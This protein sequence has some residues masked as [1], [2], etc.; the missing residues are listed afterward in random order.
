MSTQYEVR[1]HGSK[2]IRTRGVRRTVVLRT[3]CSRTSHAE[4]EVATMRAARHFT[5]LKIWQRARQGSKEVFFLAREAPFKS[6]RRPVKQINDSSESVMSN[7]AE[8]FD[9]GTPGGVHYVPWLC[10]RE[11][12]RNAEPSGRRLRPRLPRPR[13]I[14]QSVQ[15]GLADPPHDHGIHQR[16]AAAAIRS[17][18]PTAAFVSGRPGVGDLRAHHGQTARGAFSSEAG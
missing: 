17:Q 6:D 1:K 9:R 16:H 18:E 5:E 2:G 10:P 11:P 3:A 13:A 15:R 7:I 4:P 14:R 12:G 8:G